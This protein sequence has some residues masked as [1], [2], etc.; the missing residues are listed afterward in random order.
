MLDHKN[1]PYKPYKVVFL[2][3]W[4]RKEVSSLTDD[5]I[6]W[7]ED[8]FGDYGGQWAFKQV[9]G[10]GRT[11][12]V[13]LFAREVHLTVFQLAWS[14]RISQIYDRIELAF[15]HKIDIDS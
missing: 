13:I 4:Q 3:S 6:H 10:P 7:L 11:V 15:G 12:G 8:R 5:V 1:S 14:D 9:T 2:L